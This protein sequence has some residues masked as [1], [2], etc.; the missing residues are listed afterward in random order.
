M[1][2]LFNFGACAL[3]EQRLPAVPAPESDPPIG[4]VAASQIS[5]TSAKRLRR[6]IDRGAP[7]GEY[8][9]ATDRYLVRMGALSAY[10]AANGEATPAGLKG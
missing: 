10:L 2:P 4:V 3:I 9:A 8:N 7:I 5:G 1:R 6:L